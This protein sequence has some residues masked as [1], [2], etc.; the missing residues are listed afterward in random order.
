MALRMT[1]GL[2]DFKPVLAGWRQREARM[3]KAETMRQSQYHYM[4]GSLRRLEA[5]LQGRLES[6][7]VIPAEWHEIAQSGGAQGKVKITLWVEADVVKFFRSL[8]RGHTTRM[9]EVLKAFVHARLAG[10][11]KGP[12]AVDYAPRRSEA[13][14]GAAAEALAAMRKRVAKGEVDW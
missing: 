2:P 10:V 14:R 8:G 3:S 7:G 13:E 11:V 9:A 5:A 4:A 6:A 12:E 1:L